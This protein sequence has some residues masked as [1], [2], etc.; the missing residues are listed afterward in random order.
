MNVAFLAAF[1]AFS[2]YNYY[3]NDIIFI[4]SAIS[5]LY[6]GTISLGLVG[7]WLFGNRHIKNF[8]VLKGGKEVLIETYNYYG[9]FNTGKFKTYQ[10]T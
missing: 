2:L 8:Y 9:L 10:V 6:L 5:K 3:T 1:F 4:N 7:L